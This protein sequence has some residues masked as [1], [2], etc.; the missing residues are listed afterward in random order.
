MATPY[1]NR[2]NTDARPARS[3]TTRYVTIHRMA[4]VEDYVQPPP[5][6]EAVARLG[7]TG[8]QGGAEGIG[9]KAVGSKTAVEEARRQAGAEARP[10]AR[11]EA[12]TVKGGEAKGQAANYAGANR[13][14]RAQA[15]E[16]EQVMA[17]TSAKASSSTNVVA[18]ETQIKTREEN[19]T[20]GNGHPVNGAPGEDLRDFS[21]CNTNE[22]KGTQDGHEDGQKR[23]SG[24]DK[25]ECEGSGESTGTNDVRSKAEGGRGAC[26]RDGP[27]D[28]G[29]DDGGEGEG[30]NGRGEDAPA[31]QQRVP[32]RRKRPL[33]PVSDGRTRTRRR[34]FQD[35]TKPS[36]FNVYTV[37][38]FKSSVG[39]ELEAMVAKLHADPS[40]RALCQQILATA[41]EYLRA[42]L[43]PGQGR[44][45]FARKSIPRGKTI[46]YYTGML[47]QESP[48]G[49]SNHSIELTNMSGLRIVIDG[50]PPHETQPKLGSMQMVN[51]SCRPN[52]EAEHRDSEDGLGLWLLH[53]A[54]EIPEGEQITFSY[55]GNFWSRGPQR[56]KKGYKI[57][58]CRCDNGSSCPKKL[59][60][61]ERILGRSM[62]TTDK[63][64]DLARWLEAPAH[65]GGT[66]ILCLPDRSDVADDSEPTTKPGPV[67]TGAASIRR[68]E[69]DQC[70]ATAT[71]P[72]EV[73]GD[74]RMAPD[75]IL[76]NQDSRQA[77]PRE[78]VVLSEGEQRRESSPVA[79]GDEGG[80]SSTEGDDASLRRDLHNA[81]FIE[82]L[83]FSGE[84]GPGAARSSEVADAEPR[85][86]LAGF[87]CSNHPSA[88]G[89]EGGLDESVDLSR[90]TSHV[91]GKKDQTQAP[92]P[93]VHSLWKQK[94][95]PATAARAEEKSRIAVSGADPQQT[96][97]RPAERALRDH[98]ERPLG[99]PWMPGSVVDYFAAR[100]GPTRKA[101]QGFPLWLI[102]T[103]Q[104]MF[105]TPRCPHPLCL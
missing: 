14:T 89:S 102:A 43:L 29:A 57:V 67:G 104:A 33:S 74:A 92:G 13:E 4:P 60:R 77:S 37:G 66:S 25:R 81:S 32:K 56:S 80:S 30:D 79:A 64:S 71:E 23:D 85:G 36:D 105:E 59:W 26:R 58:T 7:N 82:H 94:A 78:R 27:S 95:L 41:N 91:K 73:R 38:P 62:T 19:K 51:H 44:V 97:P 47:V 70:D 11:T 49:T 15:G 65:A 16:V 12:Y 98:L 88:N 18:V 90:E 46:C 93:A 45:F 87:V 99:T 55:E 63:Q 84:L 31:G 100:G 72:P 10:E 103:Q 42:Q 86:F 76:A 1:K 68:E 52:C 34:F 96:Q 83:V 40:I 53:T 17:C 9:V 8:S 28:G 50:T 22:A 5:P 75:M 24:N 20:R 3:H 48:Q 69:G 39:Q 35:P 2:G 6:G 101:E 54:R 61:L 21:L